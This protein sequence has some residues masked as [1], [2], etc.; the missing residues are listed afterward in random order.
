[1]LRLE[2][3]ALFRSKT[4]A[5]PKTLPGGDTG[6]RMS[7]KRQGIGQGA[8]KKA[9]LR[10]L[11]KKEFVLD[12]LAAAR[13]AR[14]AETGLD[15]PLLGASLHADYQVVFAATVPFGAAVFKKIVAVGSL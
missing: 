14:G 11:L 6:R 15:G 9:P 1:M 5:V 3:L 4:K 8:N 10:G 12:S 2:G 7:V 13:K